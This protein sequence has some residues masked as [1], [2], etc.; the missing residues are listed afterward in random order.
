MA[1]TPTNTRIPQSFIRDLINRTDIVDIVRQRVELKKKGDNYQ[2]RC[3]FHD[4]K[5]PSFTVS[6]TK[7]FYYCFGCGAHGNV[8]EFLKQY[9]RMEFLDAI[10]YLA[11]RH[12]MDIPKIEGYTPD[13][14]YDALFPIMQRAATYY[15]QQ[16]TQHPQAIHYLKSRGLTGQIAKLFSLGFAPPGWDNL[17]K[18]MGNDPKIRSY[19]TNAGMLIDRDTSSSYDRFRNRIMFPI[20]DLR[21]RVIAFGG[22]TMGDEQPKYLN[23]PETPI[24]HKGQELYGLYQ[25]RQ[26]NQKLEHLIIVEGYMDVISL[27]QHG[28]TYAVATLG[29]AINSKHLQKCLR[30]SSTILF[31]FDGDTAGR[32]AAW[33][34]LTIAMPLLRDGVNLKFLFLEDGEDPDSLIQKKGRPFFEKLILDA[35]PLQ[36]VFFETLQN[37]HP[38]HSTADK[39]SLAKSAKDY[40]SQMPQGIYQELLYDELAT[41]IGVSRDEL[42]RTQ[43]DKSRYQPEK[44][45]PLPPPILPK[46]TRHCISLLLQEPLLATEIEGVEGLHE[47]NEHSDLLLLKLI[48]IFK[49]HPALPVGQLLTHWDNPQEQALIAEL[50]ATE[51]PFPR[52]G[53]SLE[54]RDTVRF[55]EKNIKQ[56]QINQLIEKSKAQS[57]TQAEKEHL[58]KLQQ[59]MHY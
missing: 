58:T 28:I 3:P 59:S 17:Q 27:F 38:G 21:G 19:L 15:Y 33:K 55:I 6:D 53:F 4:E 36:S 23:S 7:Q 8:L 43:S 26:A 25:A 20:H 2:G 50:A 9:D 47:S 51:L 29:T 30:F 16:L 54:F 52:S 44:S 48:H 46:L 32:H 10:N 31:C 22:R 34:A 49:E 37:Q 11:T 56:Q 41:L 1:D 45:M 24:F 42:E 12:G 57:L 5:T 35:L 13:R 18:T 14:S 39:A 40:I